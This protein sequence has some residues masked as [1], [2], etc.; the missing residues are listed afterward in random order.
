MINYCDDISVLTKL[1][2]DDNEGGTTDT[3]SNLRKL[4]FDPDLAVGVLEV[5][6]VVDGE[7]ANSATV[8]SIDYDSGIMTYCGLTGDDF[9]AEEDISNHADGTIYITVNTALGTIDSV[10]KGR[11]IKLS[12]IE[13]EISGRIAEKSTHVLYSADKP[14]LPAN[15]IVCDGELYEVVTSVK[16]RDMFGNVKNVETQLTLLESDE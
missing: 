8:V 3:W 10:F 11:L 12:G 2:A 7:N 13:G 15:R 5:G 4:I 14:I 6:D 1:S 9:V 16:H